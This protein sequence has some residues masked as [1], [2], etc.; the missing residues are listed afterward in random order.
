[1]TRIFEQ[2]GS[3]TL[4]W[5][6]SGSMGYECQHSFQHQHQLQNLL[7]KL[8]S[9]NKPFFILNI[10]QWLESWTH[11]S[12]LQPSGSKAPHLGEPSGFLSSA[13]LGMSLLGKDMLHCLLRPHSN[14]FNLEGFLL[15]K[16][17]GST[18]CLKGKVM[19][20][21]TLS[22]TKLRIPLLYLPCKNDM[23]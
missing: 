16:G 12:C 10:L 9:E 6:P 3:Q 19:S 21:Y 7:R 18:K 2:H 5:P 13:D 8:N 15:M 4:S 23:I 22:L 14:C 20:I 1:M 11:P 17:F